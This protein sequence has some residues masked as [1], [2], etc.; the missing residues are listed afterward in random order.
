MTGS[1]PTTTEPAL[2]S[3][4]ADLPSVTIGTLLD[5]AFAD[6]LTRA[7]ATTA[8]VRALALFAPDEPCDL[9]VVDPRRVAECVAEAAALQRYVHARVPCVFYTANTPQAFRSVL[10]LNDV[11]AARLVLFDID[12][13]PAALRDVIALAPRTSHAFRLRGALDDHLRSLLPSVRTTLHT[14]LRRPDQFFDASDVALRAG[15]SRRHLDRVLTAASLAPAKNWIVGAR[16]WH[17]VH[18]LTSGRCSVEAT[19][20]RLGY[21]D[22]KAL[23]RHLVAVWRTSPTQLARADSEVLLRDLVCFLRTRE[24]ESD[25][26]ADDGASAPPEFPGRTDARESR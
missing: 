22:R 13:E 24:P 7:I 20:A 25:L 26:A 16:A 11:V 19:A 15:L 4:A 6:R 10:A 12:D 9:L 23:R 2:K 17:A 5:P 3:S 21:A 8:F 14:I 18:L 1:T